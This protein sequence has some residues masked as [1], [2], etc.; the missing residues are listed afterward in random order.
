VGAVNLA[1]EQRLPAL[2]ADSPLFDVFELDRRVAAFGPKARVRVLALG[3]SHGLGALRP[4]ALAAVW[5]YRPEEVFNLCIPGVNARAMLLMA[6]HYLPAFPNVRLAPLMVD[7]TLVGQTWGLEPGLRYYSRY[8][9]PQRVAMLPWFDPLDRQLGLLAGTLLPVLDQATLLR[10]AWARD[11][12]AFGR[13]LWRGEEHLAPGKPNA[14]AH[15]ARHAAGFP[16]PWDVPGYFPGGGPA[17]FTPRRLKQRATQFTRQ[18]ALAPV[19]FADL[20]QACRFLEARRIRVLPIASPVD[21]ALTRQLAEPAHQAA[22]RAYQDARAAFERTRPLVPVPPMPRACFA[23]EDHM[24]GEGARRLA[25]A[26]AA[27]PGVRP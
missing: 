15:A 20:E 16:P 13:A 11:P 10:K 21:A 5:G 26:L 27:T 1:V 12:R 7:E 6:R 24:N 3:N 8:D 23:D 22:E 9:L 4:A 17:P 19:G 2:L 14:L 18:L 25:A